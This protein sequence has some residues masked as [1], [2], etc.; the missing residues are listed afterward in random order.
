MEVDHRARARDRARPPRPA[1]RTASSSTSSPTATWSTR[2]S[3][4]PPPWRSACSPAR[5]PSACPARRGSVLEPVTGASHAAVVRYALVLIGA[6]TTLIVTLVLF[7][8]PVGQLLLGGALTSVFVGIAAQQSL[9]NVF[10]GMVLL[11]AHPFRVG[12]AIRLRAGRPV[13]RDQRHGDRDRHHLRAHGQ[14]HRRAL[15]PELAGA[16]RGRRPAAG[17]RL[18][19]RRLRRPRRCGPRPRPRRPR[20]RLRPLRPGR[21]PGARAEPVARTAGTARRR[22]RLA[23][24]TARAAP[25]ARV[26]PASSTPPAAR[27]S[28]SAESL[29][30][31]ELSGHRKRHAS[32]RI[33]L[34]F[35]R[36]AAR[37]RACAGSGSSAARRSPRRAASRASSRRRVHPRPRAEVDEQRRACRRARWPGGPARRRRRARPGCRPA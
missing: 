25:P 19:A 34:I 20:P 6:V 2:S 10:A 12:D 24:P 15:H 32:F 14:Q 1:G 35:S 36:P 30:G 22:A 4:R 16:Q 8:I 29:R 23:R 5:P 37:G 3:P 31:I 27:G 9:S 28:A 18:P 7:G 21:R 13:R 11:L 26:P 33:S 17:G